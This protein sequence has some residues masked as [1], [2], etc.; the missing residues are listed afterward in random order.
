[1]SGQ[2]FLLSEQCIGDCGDVQWSSRQIIVFKEKILFGRKQIKKAQA[3]LE[4]SIP[5]CWSISDCKKAK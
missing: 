5:I 1:M 2:L 3:Q 4:T